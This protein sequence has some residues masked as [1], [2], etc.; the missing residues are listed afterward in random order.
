MQ[1]AIVKGSVDVER[2]LCL[3]GREPMLKTRVIRFRVGH[4]EDS[5]N[6]THLR[7]VCECPS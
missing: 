2:S 7:A 1:P 5:E 4:I 3:Y 6:S